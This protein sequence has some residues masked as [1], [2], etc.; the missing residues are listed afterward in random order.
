MLTTPRLTLLAVNCL[1]LLV[2]LNILSIGVGAVFFIFAAFSVF[3]S[4]TVLRRNVTRQEDY[5]RQWSTDVI[6]PLVFV[7]VWVALTLAVADSLLP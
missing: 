6:T 3:Y 5:K 1:L 7:V 2:G 4:L